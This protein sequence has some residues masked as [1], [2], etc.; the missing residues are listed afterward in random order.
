MRDKLKA[1]QVTRLAKKPGMHNDGDGLNLRVTSPSSVSWIFRFQRLGRAREHGLGRYPDVSLA[2]A[3]RAAGEARSLIAKGLDPIEARR[4]EK[5]EGLTFAHCAEAYVTAHKSEWGVKQLSIWRQ[6]LGDYAEPVIGALPVDVVTKE[7]VLAILHP[8]WT[9]KAETASRLRA[10]IESILDWANFHGHRAGENPARWRGHLQHALAA[11]SAHKVVHRAALPF[12]KLAGF[13]ADLRGQ[14][15][16]AARALEFTILTCARAGETIGATWA[17][18]DLEGRLWQ[19]PA[20]RMKMHRDHRVPLCDRALAI[21]GAPGEGYLFP[22]VR[23]K[24]LSHSAMLG[25]ATRHDCTVHGFRSV[26]RD[27]AAE[28]TDFPGEMAELALAHNVGSKVEAAYRRGDMFEKRRAMM[29]EWAA[30]CG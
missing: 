28:H 4:S 5:A 30:V 17:E 2:D 13:M 21:L 14:D 18:I 24:P 6:S 25:I 27:W 11:P 7:H 23:G 26:F 16:I 10:R 22:G 8:I 12:D 1:L 29:V 20:E 3:R 19:V 15:I 9:T